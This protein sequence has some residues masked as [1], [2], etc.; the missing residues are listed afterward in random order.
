MDWLLSGKL[1][2]PRE[3]SGSLVSPLGGASASPQ[4]RG[5]VHCSLVISGFTKSML[6][7][8]YPW[9]RNLDNHCC[10]AS[11]KVKRH[12]FFLGGDNTIGC[13]YQVSMET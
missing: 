10:Q 13:F 1:E 12:V 6:C 11:L 9:Q 2:I 4:F 3:V 7:L 8:C 5:Y